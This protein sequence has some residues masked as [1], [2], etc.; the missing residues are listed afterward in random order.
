MQ[1]PKCGFENPG[2]SSFCGRCG[3]SMETICPSCGAKP[4]PDFKFCHKCGYD[5]SLEAVPDPPPTAAIT[6]E[7]TSFA[8]DRYEVKEFLGEGGKKK[9]YKAY[10]TLLDRDV[11][12]SLIKLGG[13][14]EDSRTRITRE[15][16]AMG[17]LGAHNNIVTV[18]D[19]GD[20]D[21]QPFIVS[22][23]MG[24]GDVEGLIEKAEKNR[25]PLEQIVEIAQAVCE[26]LTFAH[27]K[28]IIHR[29]LKP[30]N[31]WLTDDGQI[32]I[33]DFGLALVDD[34]TRLTQDGMMVGT[35]S[36]LPPEQAMGGE[37]TEKSDLYSLGAML[38]EM[39]T[40]RPPFLGDDNVAIIGQHLNTPPVSP[41]WHNPE[42]PQALETL[43]LR[44]L[45][46]NAANRSASALEVSRALESIQKGATEED[47]HK[48]DARSE[49]SGPLY[50]QVF[51]GRE[52]ELSQ[53]KT[54][55]DNALSGDGS[56]M[57]VVG[58]PGVG[59]TAITEQIATYATM[60]GG[61][62]LVGHCYEEGSLSLP[63]LAFVEAMRTYVLSRE[64]NELRQ[65]MGTGASEVARIVSE[66]RD[67][68]DVTPREASNPDEDRYR[69]FQAV[70][71]FLANASEVQ[72]LLIVLEDLHDSDKGTL[73]LLTHITRN[74]NNGRLLIVGTYR[75]VEVDRTHP[76]SSTLADLRRVSSFERVLLRGLTIDEVHR[77]LSGLS[78]QDV[79]W[80]VAE[81]V[82]RQTE[83]NPLFVQE[84]LRYAV[85]DGLIVRESGEWR[86][87]D[88]DQLVMSIPE[89]LRDVI[90]KRLSNLSPECGQLLSM[91]SVMGREFRF[92]VL[93]RL[94]DMPEEDLF[95]AL[96]EAISAAV[97]EERTQTAAAVIY[98][99]T[100]AFIRQTLYEE[101]IAPHR[102]R[103]HQQIAQALEEVFSSRLEDHAVELAEHFSHSTHP[104]D[105][106]KAV[107]YGEMAANRAMAVFDYGEAVRSL[108]Q[109]LQIQE[110]LDPGDQEKR[111]ALLLDLADALLSDGQPRRVLDVEVAEAFTVAEKI[112]DTG[113]AFKA[114]EIAYIAL[115]YYGQGHALTSP[116]ALLWAERTDHLAEPGT[117]ERVLADRF[118]GS[119]QAYLKPSKA[120]ILLN[121]ALKSVRNFNNPEILHS[122]ANA[123]MFFQWSHQ[124]EVKQLELANE[125]YEHSH[126][127][128]SEKT[129]SQTLSQSANVFLAWGENK[130]VDE[131]FI[132]ALE[133]AKKLDQPTDRLK[134]MNWDAFQFYMDGDLEEAANAFERAWA[135]GKNLDLVE[136]AKVGLYWTGLKPFILLGE[137]DRL[138]ALFKEVEDFEFGASPVLAY[139]SRYEESREY[140]DRR[141][142]RRDELDPA[143]DLYATWL[144]IL[145]LE[146]AVLVKHHKAAD[147]LYR[148]LS[149]SNLKTTAVWNMT[150][151][152]R[153]K[154]AAAIML[155]KIPEAKEHYLEAIRFCAEMPF[156]LEL[157]LSRFELAELQF[158]HFPD[159]KAEAIEHLDFAIEEFK[160]VKMRP[161][162]EKAEALKEKIEG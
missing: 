157:A 140:L 125:M 132:Q 86:T 20:D 114:I 47:P 84:V 150:S 115:N 27:G 25:L 53:L 3:A 82:F 145:F 162:L 76:L 24:G 143:M 152:D 94:A 22:E 42:I 55:F 31:I 89:G 126:E 13:L 46:K 104:D 39:A 59:K 62:T 112:G 87:V 98:R 36:Y 11:A 61:T 41:S 74:I 124:D 12:F 146:A 9:V 81:A 19:L 109:T 111:C 122:V 33:G 40:G 69:L 28:G 4:P 45:E 56:L 26:G 80:Q 136:N 23:L 138:A 141:M 51:V 151:A 5:L 49:K 34:R 103:L 130:K 15:A 147:Y 161:S 75:D 135:L 99:F 127:G 78:G 64:A 32:K 128:V 153:Q 121:Q 95:K 44:L 160:E 54:A 101:M 30:G 97:I 102:N 117:I 110:V 155:G 144:D 35:V 119:V 148:K 6:P 139:L 37:V 154:G 29:D 18:F 70:T 92:E 116:E 38:Y 83:G 48:E 159:E 68:L 118:L 149:Y 96:Q 129:L 17:R 7:P 108:E 58:E 71:D 90:G 142:I 63:Y 93:Q 134:I 120:T 73:D 52:N 123:W 57:M 85:E 8:D 10:D 156:R 77:M 158:E 14:D 1:C 65:A 107:Q 131:L 50:R 106:T 113:L 60:R 67:K 100:H 21:G 66:V 91:G 43:I 137:F 88:P 72:P 105:L 2:D 133:R 16:Q 79:P